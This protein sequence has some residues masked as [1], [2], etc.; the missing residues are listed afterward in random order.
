MSQEDAHEISSA[1][2]RLKSWQ[3]SLEKERAEKQIEREKEQS[4]HP[5]NLVAVKQMTSNE[6]MAIMR[7]FAGQQPTSKS[8]DLVSAYLLT[9][10]LYANAQRP[11]GVLHMT[12]NN[13]KVM[14]DHTIIKVIAS[15]GK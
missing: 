8:C 6:S 11:G 14:K 10:M 1:I 2:K 5:T 7:E 3:T 4:E 15:L 13:F 12:L 9:V